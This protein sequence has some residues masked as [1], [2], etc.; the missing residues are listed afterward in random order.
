MGQF[1]SIGGLKAS[2]LNAAD[3]IDELTKGLFV[4]LTAAMDVGGKTRINLITEYNADAPN[5]RCN[6]DAHGA[7]GLSL[8]C[9]DDAWR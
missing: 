9:R 2:A 5:H 3:E 7:F 1:L 4:D 8:I 6:L